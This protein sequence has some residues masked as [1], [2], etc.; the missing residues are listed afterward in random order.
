MT[1]ADGLSPSIVI[2]HVDSGRDVRDAGWYNRPDP[3]GLLVTIRLRHD[4][5]IALVLGLALSSAAD[6]TVL[7]LAMNENAVEQ[8][9]AAAIL[10]EVYRK[11]GLEARIEP[12]PGARA[13][14]NLLAGQLD[15]EVARVRS[16][17]ERNPT[18]VRV[19][20]SYYHLR[21]TAFARDGSGIAVEGKDDLR[22]YRVGHVRGIAHAE[23]IA[24]GLPRVEVCNGYEQLYRM[25]ADG[26]IDVAV[27]TDVNGIARLR[28]MGLKNI[29]PVG[30][31]ARLELFHILAPA[32]SAWA[33]KI[34]AAIRAM[35]RSGELDRIT[36][37]LEKESR[38][39]GAE[40]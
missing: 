2:V 17:A 12:L 34:G 28:A 7:R 32:R 16:Y 31:L 21:T 14:A 18:L 4:R 3:G 6:P 8:S 37:R 24:E 22:P 36:A 27:D 35:R 5:G 26:R 11:A 39:A 10:K 38:P 40:P 20:P 30:T 15:G 29:V 23:A 1:E 13:N 9:I 19:E 25:L 33:P